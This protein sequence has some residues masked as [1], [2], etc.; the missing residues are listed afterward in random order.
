MIRDNVEGIILVLT[1][2]PEDVDFAAFA[3]TLVVERLA[4][5]VSVVTG[6]RSIYR[7]GDGVEDSM[8]QQVLIKTG[9]TCIA[10][11]KEKLLE[12]HP[13]QLPEFLI[14]QAGGD[15]RYLEWINASTQSYGMDV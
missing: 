11:L 1:T 9:V 5:C 2:F 8:E 6:V 4:A 15:R 10:P 13:Y 14:V 3:R 12:L 7:W